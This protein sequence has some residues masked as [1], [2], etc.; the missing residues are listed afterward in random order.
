MDF[1]R[2]LTAEDKE[3]IEKKCAVVSGSTR[4]TL[5]FFLSLF[6]SGVLFGDHPNVGLRLVIAAA[7]YVVFLLL[8]SLA[9]LLIKKKRELSA[10]AAV[11]QMNNFV[12]ECTSHISEF[13]LP[14][15]SPED[16]IAA[17]AEIAYAYVGLFSVYFQLTYREL[18]QF[19]K[20]ESNL[21]HKKRGNENPLFFLTTMYLLCNAAC[22]ANAKDKSAAESRYKFYVEASAYANTYDRI[23]YEKESEKAFRSGADQIPEIILSILSE[24]PKDQKIF[25]HYILSQFYSLYPKLKGWEWRI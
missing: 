2:Y 18:P 11:K 14:D 13:F 4:Y 22:I 10:T 20:S 24:P 8:I 25:T 16:L 19:R 6:T 3:C 17:R 1:K 9:V 5:P 23:G 7:C 21:F 12:L 15:H